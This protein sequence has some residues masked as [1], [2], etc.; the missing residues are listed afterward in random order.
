M[1][2]TTFGFH[3]TAE[4]VTH[5]VD[6]GGTTWLVTGMNSGIGRPSPRSASRGRASGAS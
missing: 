2:T 1:T 4:E 6:L 3:S 5:G